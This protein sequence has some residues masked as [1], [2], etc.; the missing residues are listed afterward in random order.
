MTAG[1]GV[2]VV[3]ARRLSLVLEADALLF[4]PSVT[5]KVGS[6]TAAYMDGLALFVHGGL[7]AR[8]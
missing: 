2:A 5:V 6:S 8:F 7:L 3:F 1:G 4:R